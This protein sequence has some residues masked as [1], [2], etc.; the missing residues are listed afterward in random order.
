MTKMITHVVLLEGGVGRW[1]QT[2]D[3]L[4]P[5]K[6]IQKRQYELSESVNSSDGVEMTKFDLYGSLTNGLES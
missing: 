4:R 3:I 6:I 1:N 2:I 5:T